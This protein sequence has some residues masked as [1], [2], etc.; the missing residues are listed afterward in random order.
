M[1][2]YYSIKN[3]VK[4]NAKKWKNK[5]I[6]NLLQIKKDMDLTKINNKII[7]EYMEEKY[8]EINKTYELKLLEEPT[9]K[10][11][12]KQKEKEIDNIIINKYYLIQ[13]GY[14]T[15]YINKYIERE[16]NEIEKKYNK[17]RIDFID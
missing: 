4:I 2:N 7:D 15:D 1:S 8:K 3:K 9:K 14:K 16:Y 12:N 13:K 11:L 10:I 6:D 17:K 5:E